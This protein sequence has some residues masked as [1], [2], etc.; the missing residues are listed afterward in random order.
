MRS[1][2]PYKNYF[3]NGP[4]LGVSVDE[5]ESC[6]WEHIIIMSDLIGHKFEYKIEGDEIVLSLELKK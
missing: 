4:I 2:R 5:F 3:E 1:N 6:L